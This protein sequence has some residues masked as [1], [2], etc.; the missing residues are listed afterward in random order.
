MQVRSLAK[1]EYGYVCT[2][3]YELQQNFLHKMYFFTIIDGSEDLKVLI[4][5]SSSKLPD[6]CAE[7]PNYRAGSIVTLTCY[8]DGIQGPGLRYSWT[9]TCKDNCLE[10]TGNE[11]QTIT[12]AGLSSSYSGLYTCT[13]HASDDCTGNATTEIKAVGELFK[14]TS[15]DANTFYMTLC[16]YLATSHYCPHN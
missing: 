3:H 13:V 14:F 9:S 6:F 10:E 5:V 11:T 7:H 4:N 12:L 15:V 1:S 8:V 2:L 16:I